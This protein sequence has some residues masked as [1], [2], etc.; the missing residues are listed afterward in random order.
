MNQT[1][2][3]TREFN[4][5]FRVYC[6][7]SKHK[8]YLLT[9][10]TEVQWNERKLQQI[11][12]EKELLDERHNEITALYHKILKQWSDCCYQR[13]LCLLEEFRKQYNSYFF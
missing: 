2:T 5:Y 3:L 9:H 12:L 4:E 8:T 1:E 10:P 13:L 6:I 7:I 11:E